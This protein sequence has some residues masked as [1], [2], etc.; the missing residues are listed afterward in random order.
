M[1]T[2]GAL[3]ILPLLLVSVAYA[4]EKGTEAPQIREADLQRVSRELPSAF[5]WPTAKPTQI[6]PVS[7]VPQEASPLPDFAGGNLIIKCTGPFL[8]EEQ[9]IEVPGS[10]PQKKEV[11]TLNKDVEIEQVQ[12][13][14][15]LRSEQIQVVNDRQT[16]KPELLK[17]VGNVEVV[18][19]ERSG[20]GD[21]LTYEIKMGPNDVTIK[22]MYTLEGNRAKN[23]KA[24]LWQGDDWIEA[25]RF[26]NDR[27]LDTFRVSGGPRA[28]FRMPG[29]D[30]ATAPVA[31]PKAPASS[32]GGGMLPGLEFG[33]GGKIKM[34]ADGEMYFEGAT[35]RLRISRNVMI[36]QEGSTDAAPGAA[37]TGL[38]MNADEVI[39]NLVLP[40]PGQPAAPNSNLLS[41]GLKSLE[42]SGRVEIRSG[43]RTVLCDRCVVDMN[44]KTLHLEMKNPKDEVRVYILESGNAGNV[45]VAPKSIT[46]NMDTGEFKASGAQ[47]MEAFTGAVPSHRTEKQ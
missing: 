38:K 6:K 10:G 31:K 23:T 24:V 35:G 9:I 1:K 28:V 42:C 43:P 44:R 17:A 46:V 15:V 26:V 21:A 19:P 20:K 2:T 33:G 37:P 39:L 34:Q 27:R 25:D 30:E 14:S 5:P 7:P 45:L 47:R 22:D 29:N 13:R 4:G 18:T 32:G 36:L 11:L 8:R 3:W 12:A 16:G 41:G 40:P